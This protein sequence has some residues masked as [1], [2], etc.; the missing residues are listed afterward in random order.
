[1]ITYTS[2]KFN[3]ITEKIKKILLD[4][5]INIQDAEQKLPES[6]IND[7]QQ[8]IS[9]LLA[10]AD[11]FL[12]V[13]CPKCGKVHLVPLA[14]TY[15]RNIIFK[16]ENI[17]VKLK[18]KVPRLKC[19]NCNSTHAILP[20]FCIPL[21]QYSTQAVLSIVSEATKTSTEDVAEQ[22]NIDSKQVRR[23]VNVVKKNINN[24]LLI[25]E[26]QTTKFKTKIDCKSSVNKIIQSL[27][28][29]FTELFFE[30]FSY[31][32]LYQK[33]KRELYMKFKKLSI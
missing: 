4:N 8:Y 32:F 10:S 14:T 18:I 26:K 24:I 12:S 19:S 15:K 3:N 5:N 27:P 13:P 17:L 22:L 6:I 30:E 16:I 25:H 33:S 23:F 1:M 29:N 7:I 20:D 21:K 2:S 31:A 9:M 28:K 11:Q